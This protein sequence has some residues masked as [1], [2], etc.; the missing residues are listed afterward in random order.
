MTPGGRG[1]TIV[2]PTFSDTI[3]GG[4]LS[5]TRATTTTDL[6]VTVDAVYAAAELL[7]GVALRTP[8]IRLSEGGDRELVKA[9]SL[10]LTG[11]FKLRG[12]HVAIAGL[13]EEQRARG[14]IAASS[15]NHAQGVAYAARAL[16]IS[17]TVVMP[18]DAP[19][20]KR[21]RTAGFGAEIIDWQEGDEALEE[22]AARIGAERDLAVIHPFNDPVVMSGQATVGLEIAQ[23]LP[24]VGAILVPIGGGG[25]AS[26]LGCA[27]R[28]LLP[29]VRLIGVEPELAA[30]MQDGFRAGAYR[31]WPADKR[32]R[33]IADG[34]RTNGSEATLSVVT[35]LYD[36]IVTVTEDEIIAAMAIAAREGRLTLEPSGATTIAA[37]RFKQAEAGLGTVSGPIVA[38]ASGGN[39]DPVS[40]A[41]WLSLAAAQAG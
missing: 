17:A 34:M 12:A 29:G 27:M 14:V 18:V 32:Q 4:T 23:D 37:M 3:H 35:A 1:P 24:D 8:L 19:A 7:R 10:Q 38:V 26:G 9:E 30:D 16:G 6:P 22:M 15:G 25:L 11:A 5:V 28:A 20:L 39:V 36:D 40:Y 21:A 41:A 13:S 2:L 31:P 33:T